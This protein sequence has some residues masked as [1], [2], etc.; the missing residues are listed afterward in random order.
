MVSEFASPPLPLKELPRDLIAAIEA[1]GRLGPDQI[2]RPSADSG[3]GR[4]ALWLPPGYP[5]R[6][7]IVRL[8][9]EGLSP[10]KIAREV[11]APGYEVRDW[12][13]RYREQ[14][15]PGLLDRPRRGR[16]RLSLSAESL[17]KVY[18]P[19]EARQSSRR[20]AAAF[21]GAGNPEEIVS[22]STVAR[23]RRAQ[24]LNRNTAHRWQVT[25]L[26]VSS[27]LRI[28]AVRE[29]RG[30]MFSEDDLGPL[31]D[32]AAA[33]VMLIATV[34]HEQRDYLPQKEVEQVARLAQQIPTETHRV[35]VLTHKGRD[36]ARSWWHHQF[37]TAEIYFAQTLSEWMRYLTNHVLLGGVDALRLNRQGLQRLTFNFSQWITTTGATGTFVRPSPGYS[38]AL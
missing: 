10:L 18:M 9:S 36:S 32:L 37:P 20:L 14:G 30:T 28:V 27:S 3:P 4:P 34:P 15:L 2:R 19:S 7:R 6:A 33:L 11:G 13:S 23:R 29:T 38:L 5:R 8:A 17:D 22:P 12:L 1:A 31:Y 21:R 25:G 35:Y 16:P 24:Q 26:Y